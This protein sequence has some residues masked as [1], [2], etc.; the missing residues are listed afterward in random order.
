MNPPV[1]VGKRH[2]IRFSS[3]LLDHGET[4]LQDWGVAI[5][6]QALLL[7]EK[8]SGHKNTNDMGTKS[9]KASN[10]TQAKW[11]KSARTKL[12]SSKRVSPTHHLSSMTE[13]SRMQGRL[14]LC[15]QSLVFEPLD[16]LR[17][18]LRF[19]FAKMIH[20]PKETS[21][22]DAAPSRSVPSSLGDSYEIPLTVIFEVTRYISI[23]ENN[24]IG[25]FETV[26]S[27]TKVTVTFL[28]SS[29][30]DVFVELCQVSY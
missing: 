15:T 11:N 29:P 9:A 25:P 30:K 4:I 18:I 26:D 22:E 24:V 20:P 10:T 3:L 2:N 12:S 5:S 17:P 14:H 1:A 28:H 16:T 6:S 23:K 8:S 27:P 7:Q 13:L 19:P 21:G